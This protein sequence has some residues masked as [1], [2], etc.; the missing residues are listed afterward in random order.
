MLPAA[1]RCDRETSVRR[2]DPAVD[3]RCED[4]RLVDEGR[5]RAQVTPE[6]LDSDA[7]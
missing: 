5:R 6:D 4:I 3:R 2:H 7:G 1:K